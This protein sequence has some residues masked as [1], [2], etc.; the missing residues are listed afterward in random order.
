MWLMKA[1]IPRC[2]ANPIVC[3]C[4]QHENPICPH[5]PFP[6]N[7]ISIFTS[8]GRKCHEASST[9]RPPTAT[10]MMLILKSLLVDCWPCSKFFFLVRNSCSFSFSEAMTLYGCGCVCVDDPKRQLVGDDLSVAD[11]KT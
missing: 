1:A 8:R 9:L 10:S 11:G 7:D 6:A 3:R 4:I 5:A 2:R